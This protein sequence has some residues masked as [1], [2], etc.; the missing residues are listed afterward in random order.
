MEC[1]Q[2]ILE[3]AFLSALSG[4]NVE[5]LHP[6]LSGLEESL[7]VIASYIDV[8]YAYLKGLLKE[9][10]LHEAVS[11]ILME[12]IFK[13]KDNPIPLG[14]RQEG[15]SSRDSDTWVILCTNH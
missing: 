13:L 9:D 6:S 10:F 15:N 8:G 3:A 12:Q 4:S 11:R 2:I 1:P 5:I 14:I 7:Q